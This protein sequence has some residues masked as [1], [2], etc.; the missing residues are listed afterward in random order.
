MKGLGGQWLSLSL[1]GIFVVTYNLSAG[2]VSLK[3]KIK[4][5][6]RTRAHDGSLALNCNAVE[7]CLPVE[8]KKKW[9]SLF[10]NM[11]FPS[12]RGA[13]TSQTWQE[14]SGIEKKGETNNTTPKASRI[15]STFWEASKLDTLPRVQMEMVLLSGGQVPAWHWLVCLFCFGHLIKVLIS[16]T[17]I[18][19]LEMRE[20]A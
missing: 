17:Y 6:R 7:N 13:I 10:S 3:M 20:K 11:L 15:R 2:Y 1:V 14:L 19:N 5:A 9:A 8:D 16:C 4:S 12:P 18:K